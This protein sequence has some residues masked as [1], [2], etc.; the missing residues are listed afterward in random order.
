FRLGSGRKKSEPTTV[1][2]VPVGA[3]PAVKQ[4]IESY[5]STP[6]PPKAPK[7]TPEPPKA[8]KS[9]PEP[10]K[11]PKSTPEPNG[12]LKPT[13]KDLEDSTK[14]PYYDWKVK[15]MSSEKRAKAKLKRKKN[16]KA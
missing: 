7:S 14:N 12:S 4:L 16:K 1:I 5:K 13:L 11:A 15:P 10:P 2:R 9:T 3:L 6:E 8:P